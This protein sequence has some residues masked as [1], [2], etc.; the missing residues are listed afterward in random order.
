MTPEQKLA[1]CQLDLTNA[2]QRV[3]EIVNQPAQVY[4]RTADAPV[5]VF[6]PG[7]FDPGASIP[8]FNTVDVRLTQQLMYQGK[9]VTSDLNPGV[10]FLGD[11]LEFNSMTKLFYADRTLP[12]HRLSDDEMQEINQQ[13]RI[14]GRCQAEI[15]ALQPPASAT[16]PATGQATGSNPAAHPNLLTTIWSLP[17]EKRVEYIGVPVV[18]LIGLFIALR[19][20]TRKTQ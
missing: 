14:I 9:W 1:A 6:H 15:R 10:M 5:S 19:L 17:Q 18:A 13:Y 12:K 8:D 11:D 4:T 2:W 3:S 7:W 16:A 20:V